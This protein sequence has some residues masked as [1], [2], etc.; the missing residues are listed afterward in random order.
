MCTFVE[1]KAFINEFNH[2]LP[3]MP[4]ATRYWTFEKFGILPEKF[5]RIRYGIND[6]LMLYFFLHIKLLL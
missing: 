4:K 6:G 5:R 2:E 1:R 3:V